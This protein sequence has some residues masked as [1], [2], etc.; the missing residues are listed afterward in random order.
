MPYKITD[1]G[2]WSRYTPD[3]LPDWAA[4]L[5]VPPGQVVY[6]YRRESDGKDWYE[7]RKTAFP[8]DSVVATTLRDP[9]N[10]VETV[11]A[12]VRNPQDIDPISQRVIEISGVDPENPKPWQLFE[13]LTYHPD[14]VT[15]SGEPGFKPPV[16]DFSVASSQA[17]IQ[18]GRMPHDGSVVPGADNLADAT[19]MLV[20]QSG[21]RELKTWFARAQ[22]WVITNP[23]VQKIGAAFKLSPEEIQAAFDAASKIQ[24]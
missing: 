16:V 22:R 21:D 13:Q 1:H 7:Y 14:T 10:G 8:A 19:E 12:I 3:K 24:E 20:Q 5:P 4:A 2:F 18:L 17:L 15:F 9:T 11:M 6:F 23:N